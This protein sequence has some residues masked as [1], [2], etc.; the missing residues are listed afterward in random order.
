V[1]EDRKLAQEA[2]ALDPMIDDLEVAKKLLD[3]YLKTFD[4]YL[5]FKL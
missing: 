1:E 4:S 5:S 3:D 2:F